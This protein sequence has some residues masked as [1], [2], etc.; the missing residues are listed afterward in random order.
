MLIKC[1]YYYHKGYDL[2]N[3]DYLLFPNKITANYTLNSGARGGVQWPDSGP[4]GNIKS[5]KVLYQAKMTG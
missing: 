2:I 1:K 5:V 3:L 4:I